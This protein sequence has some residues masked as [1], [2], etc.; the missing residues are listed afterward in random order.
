MTQSQ[1]PEVQDA[2]DKLIGG[3]S[4]ADDTIFFMFTDPELNYRKTV[5]TYK[6]NNKIT[7]V[8]YF[9]TPLPLSRNIFILHKSIPTNPF[10]HG[11]LVIEFISNDTIELKYFNEI[12]ATLLKMSSG[13]E[14][15][16]ED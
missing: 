6:I 4:N 15:V 13:F 7:S 5:M 12:F 11:N 1:I 16:F 2:Y 8:K 14:K 10:R 9:L 3:W